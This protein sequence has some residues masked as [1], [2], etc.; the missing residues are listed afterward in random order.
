MYLKYATAA[1]LALL[2]ATLVQAQ[3]PPF[4]HRGTQPNQPTQPGQVTQPTTQ[5]GQTQPGQATPQQTQPGQVTQ[6]TTA[7]MQPGLLQPNQPTQPGLV[8][9]PVPQPGQAGQARPGQADVQLPV[10][11]TTPFPQALF[12][13]NDVAR[14][15]NVTQLQ[16]ERLNQI[17]QQLQDRFRVD[18]NNINGL[19]GL[20]PQERAARLQQLN[21]QYNLTWMNGAQNVFDAQQMNRYR[22]LSLQ[23]GGFRSLADPQI[24][25]QLNL[26]NDQAQQLTGV[27]LWSQQQLQGIAQQ[28]ATDPSQAAVLYRNYQ[29]QA[30]TRLNGILSPDQQR[31]WQGMV[32]DPFNFQ[33]S[34]FIPQP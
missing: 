22:Q 27:N 4:G 19:T 30:Q 10:G 29:A 1:G 18:L 25:R 32:G 3:T 28:A 11:Q 33:M 34:D 2:L 12:R 13:M 20:T 16:T 24:Q 5:P 17:T 7:P 21:Q 26:T 31:A 8:T 14:S 6:P 23:F 15:L 9:Q